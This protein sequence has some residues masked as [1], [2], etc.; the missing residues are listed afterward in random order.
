MKTEKNLACNALTFPRFTYSGKILLSSFIQQLFIEAY[1][2]ANT[3]CSTGQ[4]MVNKPGE[5]PYFRLVA[6]LE[7]KYWE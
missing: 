4:S 6:Y 7:L 3:N 2:V 5:N 1:C